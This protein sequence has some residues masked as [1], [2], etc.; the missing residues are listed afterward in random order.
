MEKNSGTHIKKRMIATAAGVLA[1]ITGY[2]YFVL[3]FLNLPVQ[4]S[5]IPRV[6]GGWCSVQGVF[7]A[8]TR[9]TIVFLLPCLVSLLL[10]CATEALEIDWG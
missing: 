9:I 3:W 10:F 6:V 5:C 7:A 4:Q 1:L 2:T 8:W